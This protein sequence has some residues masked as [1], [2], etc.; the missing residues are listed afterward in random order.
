MPQALI[1]ING[2]DGS[3]TDLPIDTIVQLDNAN[4]GGEIT[5]AWTILDQPPGAADVLSSTSIQNPT[6]TPKKEGSYLV[7]LVVNQGQP[8][9]Q[10]D[11][12]VAAVRQ[13]KTRLRVP[14]AGEEVEADAADGWAT[15]TN[16]QLRRLDSLYNAEFGVVVGQA[17][18][19]LNKGEVVRCVGTATIKS[20]LPG[21]E[22][23][24]TFNKALAT[25]CPNVDELL[26]VVEGGIDG[27]ASVGLGVL[28]RVRIVGLYS[29]TVAGSP[30]SGDPVYVSDTGTLSLTSGQ[31]MRQVGTAIQPSGGTYRLWVFG[32]IADNE[33]AL[34]VVVPVRNETGAQLNKGTLVS[35][36]GYSAPEA[37]YLVQKAD[38]DDGARRP[39]IGVLTADLPNNTN[40]EA[41]VSGILRNVDTSTYSLTDQL[42][43]GDEGVFSRPP[44]DVSPFTG[45]V[46]LVGSVG[47]VHATLGE[48]VMNVGQGMLPTT[49][50]QTF[51]LQGT[52]GTPSDTNRY[53]T[54]S[55]QRLIP[56]LIA[57][58]NTS[59]P[60]GAGVTYLDPWLVD[61]VSGANEIQMEVTSAGVLRRLRVLARVAAGGDITITVRV[62]GGDSAL[63]AVLTAAAT[64]VQDLT[65]TVVVA[66]GDRISVKC[67]KTGAGAPG[68]TDVN[69]TFE[70]L[71]P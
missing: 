66:A 24:P 68:L 28:V 58:G 34:N 64:A 2:V 38:K 65:H 40:A 25:A 61:R 47:R 70:Q 51:A 27:A 43:L 11:T 59:T 14:A 23:V 49:A 54:D 19:A 60:N 8:S 21:A 12:V 67:D 42:V 18:A 31:C 26:G 5:Y 41:L 7:K 29:T 45:E 50:A 13:L 20:G 1:K 63:T 16:A 17:A 6:F 62:N 22:V 52:D 71:A 35:V 37:R 44:I 32:G 10:V 53:V 55:D 57:F 4:I 30:A 69:V 33:L 3:N 9:E 36:S 39:A 48:I 56:T 15:D 46:Q